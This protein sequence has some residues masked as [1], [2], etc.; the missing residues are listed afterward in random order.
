MSFSWLPVVRMVG[1]RGAPRRPVS[2]CSSLILFQRHPQTTPQKSA[3]WIQHRNISRT[4]GLK[5]SS[6]VPKNVPP[7][8]HQR[9]DASWWRRMFDRETNM[10]MTRP[11]FEDTSVSVSVV[12]AGHTAFI[13]MLLAY[14]R[15]DILEL[16]MLAISSISF[17][18]IYQYF[19]PRPLYLPLA[20]NSIFLSLNI[21]MATL[22]YKEYYDAHY[23][24]SPQLQGIFQNGSFGVR[25]FDK[26]EFNRLFSESSKDKPTI[27][28]QGHILKAGGAKSDK[29][30]YL[31]TEGSAQVTSTNGV[32]LS[33]LEEFDFIGEMEFIQYLS[34]HSEN[35]DSASISSS[36][37]ADST[38]SSNVD[39][40][41]DQTEDGVMTATDEE[42]ILILGS[43]DLQV[44][45]VE[46]Q[47]L[48]TKSSS[49]EI[50]RKEIIVTNE[51]PVLP[52][53]LANIVVNS[54]S[55]AT[56]YE[57]D[58]D[59]LC[60]YFQGTTQERNLANALLAYISHEL[61]EK[62]AE[63]WHRLDQ[64]ENQHVDLSAHEKQVLLDFLGD[65][66]G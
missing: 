31:I 1:L 5:T 46:K 62:L 33:Q 2:K 24:M 39:S 37:S 13:L 36:T 28:P 52:L 47:M 59:T 34:Q 12:V 26:V 60:K 17:T 66:L 35:A 65:A 10:Y 29:K 40:M 21:T 32:V 49:S 43:S 18:M 27:Y 3:C 19:R 50:K 23:R 61:Q 14:V 56:V 9:N 25:G 64:Q 51:E 45:N 20:W 8:T 38:R 4:I 15:R 22:L 30:L 42:E 7:P 44:D 55:G 53:S 48:E 16:R 57:W 54:E 63:A 6:K 41:I 11:L 58:F